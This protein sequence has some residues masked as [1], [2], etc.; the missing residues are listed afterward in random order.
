[1]WQRRIKRIAKKLK[2]DYIIQSKKNESGVTPK[3]W[4]SANYVW[5]RFTDYVTSENH[6][7]TLHQLFNLIVVHKPQSVIFTLWNGLAPVTVFVS[8]TEHSNLL[9]VTVTEMWGTV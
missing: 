4:K 2:T 9:C 3:C 1:M 8:P 7:N 6:Y 5:E